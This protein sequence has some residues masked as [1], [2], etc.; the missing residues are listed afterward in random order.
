[1]QTYAPESYERFFPESTTGTASDTHKW[2]FPSLVEITSYAHELALT[3]LFESGIQHMPDRPESYYSLPKEVK[4]FLSHLPATW[5]D[6]K[7]LSGYPGTDIVLARRKGK[8][9]YI[10]GINGTNKKRVLSFSTDRL[11]I[12][13]STQ[14]IMLKDGDNSKDFNISKGK[15]NKNKSINIPCLPM[16]GFLI[17]TE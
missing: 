9:W 6:T 11:K 17:V 12:D 2:R 7:L 15:I 16:G 4:E 13:K 14:C 10:S 3:T 5:D 1:M 8:R